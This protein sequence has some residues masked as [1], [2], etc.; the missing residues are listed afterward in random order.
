MSGPRYKHDCKWCTYIGSINRYDIY[1]CPQAG[2]PTI[3][4]RWNSKREDY[5]SGARLTLDGIRFELT[6]AW[7]PPGF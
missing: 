7:E 6:A 2:N 5:L 4:A 1:T 3:V